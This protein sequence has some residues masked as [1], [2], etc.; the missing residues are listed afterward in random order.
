MAFKELLI[1]SFVGEIGFKPYAFFPGEDE[2]HLHDFKKVHDKIVELT[3]RVC[4]E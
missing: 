1:D 4:G 3:N 2:T